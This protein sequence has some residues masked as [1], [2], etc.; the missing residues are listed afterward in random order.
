MEKFF[1]FLSSNLWIP[2]WIQFRIETNADPQHLIL[3]HG[4]VLYRVH[5]CTPSNLS[6][7]PIHAVLRLDILKFLHWFCTKLENIWISG[8][9]QFLRENG[10]I[11]NILAYAYRA[12]E[13]ILIFWV[14]WY[15]SQARMIWKVFPWFQ[16]LRNNYH[17]GPVP[18]PQ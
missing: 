8:G 18:G 3:A 15:C 13:L 4:T 16:V 6:G 11:R 5:T 1:N 10:I 9:L 12:E 14:F 17:T 7:L 2:N